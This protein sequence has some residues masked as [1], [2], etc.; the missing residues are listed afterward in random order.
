MEFVG[1]D[2]STA[3]G[4]IRL[5]ESG[6]LISEEKIEEKGKD[7]YRMMRLIDRI[8]EQIEP[9]DV[10]AIEGFG[11]NSQKGFILGGIGWS[12]RMKLLER[13]LPYLECS[14]GTLKNYAGIAGNKGKSDMILAVY[15]RFGY[16]QSDDD[17][18]D[19]YVLAELARGYHGKAKVLKPQEKALQKATEVKPE[20]GNINQ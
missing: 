3:T 14:P 4:V 1:L 2:V 16:R 8:M 17:L 12:V 10:V 19:A 13:G 7:P 18:A 6:A 20:K 9:D 11:F 15:D 5:S